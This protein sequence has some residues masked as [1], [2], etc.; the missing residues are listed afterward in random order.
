MGL[1]PLVCLAGTLAAFEKASEDILR[2]FAG[3]RLS[4]ATTLRVTEAAGQWLAEQLQAGQMVQ[5]EPAERAWEFTIEGHP[6]TVAYV[7]LDAFSVPMQRPDGRKR[8][9]RM[10][11]LGTLYTPDKS[12][13]RYLI[14]FD[15]QALAARLRQA[16]TA[17]GLGR[18]EAVV[19]ITDGG[20]G[21]EDAL[22]RNFSSG[23]VCVLD[24]YHAMGHVHDCAAVLHAHDPTT[25][26]AW[27]KEAETLL[28]E[29]GG[30]ALLKWLQEGPEPEGPD[31]QEAWRSLVVYVTNQGHRMDYPDYRSRGWDVGSG[32]TEAGCKVVGARLK[33]S[34]MRWCEAGAARVAALRA[35]Y[36]SGPALWDG[37]WTQSRHVA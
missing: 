37:F 16:A 29:K 32:P 17:C 9:G 21:L 19:G 10:L 23:M 28:W 26:R 15:L 2:R 27:S 6:N 18:A 34:G 7:G 24:W 33:G 31:G 12:H 1:R 30:A 14:D 5:P 8:E 13:T 11:Y 20:N 4:A 35:L 36:E 25:K 22:Q 3:V